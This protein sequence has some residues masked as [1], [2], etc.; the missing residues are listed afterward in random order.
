MNPYFGLDER[1]Y[2]HC[3]SCYELYSCFITLC[4]AYFA[5]CRLRYPHQKC[6]VFDI[7]SGGDKQ[8]LSTYAFLT[9]YRGNF[10]SNIVKQRDKLFE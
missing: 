3:N 1:G 6:Y 2:I 5:M 4:Q 10:F 8:N 9:E 7:I